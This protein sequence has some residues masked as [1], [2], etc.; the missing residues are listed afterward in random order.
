MKLEIVKDTRMLL[1]GQMLR[2]AKNLQALYRKYCRISASGKCFST[3]TEEITYGLYLA[4]IT[5]ATDN[6]ED[7]TDLMAYYRKLIKEGLN[8]RKT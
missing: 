5:N 7:W 1:P 2:M 6:F 8:E 4:D 3:G